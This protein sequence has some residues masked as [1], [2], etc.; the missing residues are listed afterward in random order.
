MV[1]ISSA[2]NA[3]KTLYLGVVADQLNTG[4]NPLFAKIKQTTSDVWGKN[5]V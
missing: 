5:I 1:T 4:I 3:L 2:E